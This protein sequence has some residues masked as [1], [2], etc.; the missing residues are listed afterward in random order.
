MMDMEVSLW[1]L[2]GSFLRDMAEIP[3]SDSNLKLA[4]GGGADVRQHI[5]VD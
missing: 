5:R 1:A 2:G 4:L 3:D